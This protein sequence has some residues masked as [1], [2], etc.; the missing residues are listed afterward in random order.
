MDKDNNRPAPEVL[1]PQSEN[2]SDE[3]ADKEKHSASARPAMKLRRGPYRPSH[4]ATFIGLAVVVAILAVN[5]GVIAFVLKGQS[6]NNA[7]VNR[8]QVTLSQASLD[9]LGMNRTEVGDKGIELTVGPNAT[10]NGRVKVASDMSVG[11]QLIL[12]S[13]FTASDA[14]LANLQA[15]NT[16][17]SQLNVNGDTS[18]SNLAARGQLLVAGQ[19]NFQ[20]TVTMSQ[21]LTVNNNL[22]VAG[23][24]AV[25]GSLS[26]GNFH[27]SS[28]V[29]DSTLTIGGHVITRGNSPSMSRGSGLRAT[30]TAAISGNDASGTVSVNVGTGSISGIVAFVS[31]RS[32]Y[33]NTP[34]VVVTAVG[35]GAS[36]VYVNRTASGFSIGVGSLST[37]GHAFD[38]IVEQ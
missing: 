20:G 36:D 17:L 8:E 22:N 35:P 32:N 1:K 10:F 7:K 33:S 28:L 31:F 19:S 18:L 11:G 29:V 30:D 3:P 4:K 24:V 26:V 13:K 9:K 6:S 15:G 25:G 16:A 23:S 12:N 37:G 5:V 34:H 27:T 21:L 2:S 38:Y 14:A